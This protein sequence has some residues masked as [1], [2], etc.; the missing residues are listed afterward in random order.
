ML[1]LYSIFA[2]ASYF[3]Y[4]TFV[5]VAIFSL[6]NSFHC[7][8]MATSVAEE[9]EKHAVDCGKSNISSFFALH[10]GVLAVPHP[11]PSAPPVSEIAAMRTQL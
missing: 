4:D 3:L 6:C 2:A 8:R 9:T 11:H 10:M 1:F 7:F 5:F